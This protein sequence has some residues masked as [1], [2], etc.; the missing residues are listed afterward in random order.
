MNAVKS[1]KTKLIISF[2]AIA[3]LIGIVG[4]NGAMSLRTINNNSEKMYSNNLQSVKYNLSIKSNMFEIR[5][6]ILSLMHEKDKF[7]IDQL[8]N[9][10]M[11]L[12]EDDNQYI[13]YYEKLDNPQ[14]EV[15]AY[16]EFKDNV[17]N[18]RNA[19]NKIIQ[20]VDLG[21]FNEAQNQ[22]EVMQPI[23]TQMLHSLDNVIQLNL[24]SADNSNTENN[25]IYVRSNITMSILTGIGLIIAIAL[26][27]FI[28]KN[29]SVSLGKMKEYAERLAS[30]DFST[31]IEFKRKDEFGQ[32]GVALNKAQANVNKLIK[33]IMENSQDI[34]ASSEEL[35]ATAQEL[36]SRVVNIDKAINDIA[37]GMQESSAATEEISA[38]VEEVNSNINELSEKASD[39]SNNANKSK[40]RATTVQIN[41]QNAIKQTKDLYSEKENKMVQVIENGKIVDNIKI[42][43][44]TIGNISAQT[45]LL[46]LNAAIEAARAGEHG[47]GFAVVAEEVKTLA[48][49]SSDAVTSIQKTISKVQ[50][51]FNSSITTGI[52]IL[53]FIDNEVNDQ[54][55][56]YQETGTQYYNDSSFVS[57]M[58]EEIASMSEEL[59]ATIG[60][61]SE[62]V[63]DM[64]TTTQKSTEQIDTIKESM[65]EATK[66]I[67]QVSQTANSQ[68]DLAQTLNEMILKFKIQ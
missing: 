35:S 20:A 61:V 38:S 33:R 46:A 9:N 60:Q 62:V 42:M 12:V 32:T 51:A 65:D 58:S 28:S 54:F 57:K 19:R 44:D 41:S 21:D 53:K 10:I 15:S 6:N 40:E 31:P 26:G 4:V 48:E 45:N 34:S 25:L 59:T 7:K 36:T 37:S 29:I 5:S 55:N 24:N 3:I 50:D 63:Q 2:L 18:Y 49:Q 23:E 43:A 67:E 64:A 1:V 39:G 56:A 30:Y 47:K 27:I 22:F 68:A 8:K 13:T 66:A 14:D 52:D 11:S 16:K 17:V